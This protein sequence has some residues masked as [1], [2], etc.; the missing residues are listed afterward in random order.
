MNQAVFQVGN[1]KNVV[2]TLRS[3]KVTNL[4]GNVYLLGE[5]GEKIPLQPGQTLPKGAH[6]LIESGTLSFTT[7]QGEQLLIGSSPSQTDAPTPEPPHSEQPRDVT[8]TQE[9]QGPNDSRASQ[10]DDPGEEKD[11]QLLHA[12]T[13]GKTKPFVFALDNQEVT[14][15]SGV[16]DPTRQHLGQY[17]TLTESGNGLWAYQPE[18][19]SDSESWVR[20]S[21]AL[22]TEHF[23]LSHDTIHEGAALS[24]DILGSSS[25]MAT[26]ALGPHGIT[27][28]IVPGTSG[29]ILSTQST[30]AQIGGMM[31]GSVNEDQRTT[32]TGRLTVIDPDAGQAEFVAQN[33]APAAHGTFTIT[34][35]GTWS[36]QLD[37]SQQAVQALKRGEPLTDTITVSSKDGSTQQITVTIIGTNDAPLIQAQSQGVRED[38][39]LLSG[40]MA[41]TDAD[42]GERLT[43]TTSARVVLL[44]E[45]ENVEYSA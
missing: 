27:V 23:F 45:A 22:R 42:H 8:I 40:Q 7:D 21:S 13:G 19:T 2:T 39:A 20:H 6:L 30:P 18:A 36:Y 32:E 37:N 28:T 43:F 14:P 41:A 29:L 1:E 35:D 25:A 24:P 26:G 44:W 31:S 33:G 5:H 34:P 15:E 11:E 10:E 12:R 3:G 9:K 38:G 17:G 16:D 4:T